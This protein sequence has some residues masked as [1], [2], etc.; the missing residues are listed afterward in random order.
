M[1]STTKKEA[2]HA[3]DNLKMYST[4]VDNSTNPEISQEPIKLI[5]DE[6]INNPNLSLGAKGFYAYL[7]SIHGNFD[8]TNYPKSKS[9]RQENVA[10]YL[11]ELEILGYTKIINNK[12]TIL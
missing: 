3:M 9:E 10:G 11:S 5:P 7:L 6:L 12:L 8:P 4:N 1:Y 2:T